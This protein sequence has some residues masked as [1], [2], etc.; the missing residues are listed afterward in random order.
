MATIRL[1]FDVPS[2]EINLDPL[3]IADNI[4]DEYNRWA[5]DHGGPEVAHE[6]LS[7]VWVGD[8]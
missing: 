5:S 1:E 8:G 2:T 3:A 7:A 6:H 4:I